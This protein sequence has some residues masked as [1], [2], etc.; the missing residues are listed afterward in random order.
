[1]W[2]AKV[3]WNLSAH[4]SA[5]F[6]T[7]R[8]F[9]F[10]KI[11]LKRAHNGQKMRHNLLLKTFYFDWNKVEELLVLCFPMQT[12]SLAAFSWSSYGPTYY[13]PIKLQDHFPASIYL[14]KLSYRNTRK[15]CEICSKLT[16]K[17]TERRQ[18]RRSGVFIVNFEPVSHLFLVFLVSVS[19]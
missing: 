13:H 14:F 18:G 6:S 1:M 3:I 7:A 8:F 15:R 9:Y 5:C 17:T 16:K 2:N 12:S 11:W 4:P 19:I 10:D